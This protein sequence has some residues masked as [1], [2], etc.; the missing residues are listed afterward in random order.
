[1]TVDAVWVDTP[2]YDG[3]AFYSPNGSRIVYRA[4]HPEPGQELDDY[5]ALLADRLIR[6]GQL[7]IWVI[8][9]DGS[10]QRQVTS[11]G[12]AS[13]AEEPERFSCGR[14]RL[15]LA[16]TPSSSAWSTTVR[17]RLGTR[18]RSR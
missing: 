13:F 7:E 6:P 12:A 2:G 18:E 9:A 1:M 16:L 5:R 3:D 8:D 11:L 14:E 15:T 4:H 10:N 17:P